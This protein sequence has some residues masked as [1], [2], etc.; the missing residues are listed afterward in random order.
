MPTITTFDV[1]K[2]YIFTF[3]YVITK[4][5]NRHK[6]DVLLDTG[7]PL[8]EFSDE[9]LQVAG[10]LKDTKENVE[11]KRGFQTQKYG[12]VVLPMIEICS[13]PI[14]NLEVYVSHFDKSWGVKALIGLD[15]FRR[16]RVTVDYKAGQLITEP[17]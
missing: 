17:F 6:F 2:R 8:T 5:G 12:K 13:H 1:S 9:A 4:T 10:L 11:L 15:F 14:N 16:F 7:A 3:A